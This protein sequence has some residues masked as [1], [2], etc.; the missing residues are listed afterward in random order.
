MAS[1]P[2][3]MQFVEEQLREAGAISHYKM[4]GDYVVYCD[5]KVWVFR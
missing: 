2:D 4:M 1:T 3:F 5:L